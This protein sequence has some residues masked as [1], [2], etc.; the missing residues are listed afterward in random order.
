MNV[1]YVKSEKLKKAIEKEEFANGKINAFLANSKY[2]VLVIKQNGWFLFSEGMSKIKLNFGNPLGFEYKEGK[3][4][5]SCIKSFYR[6]WKSLV[7]GMEN[8][9]QQLKGFDIAVLELEK[10]LIVHAYCYADGLMIVDKDVV[11]NGI[12]TK[13]INECVVDA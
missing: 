8:P 5:N 10:E 9:M 2:P 6:K 7:I 13:L 1:A 3:E 4:V 11:K 12:E